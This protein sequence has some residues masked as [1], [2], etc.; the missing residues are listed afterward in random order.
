M[1]LSV[2]AATRTHGED[3]REGATRV[4]RVTLPPVSRELLDRSGKRP[5]PDWLRCP[6]FYTKD[7]RRPEMQTR[8]PGDIARMVVEIA[9][10]EGEVF[11]L[12]GYWGG[13]VYFQSKVAPHAPGLGS[14]D[15]L[16]EGTEEGKRRGVKIVMYMNPNALFPEHPLFQ[17]VAARLPNGQPTDYGRRDAIVICTNHPRFREF[18]AEVVA[19]GFSNYDVE[20][21]YVDGLSPH[22]CCCRHCQAKYRQM[23]NEDLPTGKL[24]LVRQ[25]WSLWEMV[26][27]PLPVGD[28]A[29]PDLDRYRQFLHRSQTEI[30][31]LVH[32]TV[33]RCKADAVVTFHTW[34][35]PETVQFYDATV[36]EIYVERPWIHK[37]WKYGELANLGSTFSIP[38]LCNI[39]LE[40]GSEAE[41]RYKMFQV[42]ANGAY[43]NCWGLKAMKPMF[44]FL[45]ENAEYYDFA[46]T[47]PVR[48][49][50]IPREIHLSQVHR[51]LGEE[52]GYNRSHEH[53]LLPGI[54]LYSALE[55]SGLPVINL[56]AADFQRQLGGFRV[57]CLSHQIGMSPEQVEQVRRFVARG[58]GLIA[59][60]ETSL[61]D[62]KA[63]RQVDFQLADVFGATFQAM[64]P[65]AGREIRIDGEEFGA[66]LRSSSIPHQESHLLVQPTTGRAVARLVGE[67]TTATGAPA[68]IVNRFGRG[69]VVY[70]P[71][72]LDLAEAKQPSPAIE[73]LFAAAV[74]WVAGGELPVEMETEDL[75]GAT[76]YDQPDRRLLHLVSHNT[77]SQFRNDDVQ[78]A[79][80]V[81]IQ[82][83]IPDRRRLV[84]VH[85]LWNKREVPFE[86]N[87]SL[88][89]CEL[90]PMGPYEV[91][92]A[93]LESQG[94]KAAGPAPRVEVEHR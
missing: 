17:E 34:P 18:R 42:V 54:G 39:Y 82:L 81:A 36:T 44:G 85:T 13:E 57:L 30:M 23:W 15:F 11:R 31:R 37:A 8:K 62:H 27:E 24:E 89:R 70:L 51:K 72:R 90:D 67:G 68:V 50:A 3:S 16:R 56:H 84:R 12:G 29:D 25:W 76:L 47:T 75:V 92:V 19:E 32:D 69:R 79:G 49:L 5:V 2:L 46:R 73:R 41:A 26:P 28:P 61:Y 91:L 6:R 21:L 35:K 64:L 66:A 38:S 20:G 33:K 86:A 87:G 58:G 60:C 7:S 94:A 74:R 40:H 45:R 93:E 88:L 48:F 14:M 78:P 4:E 55:R 10:N 63:E 53:F 9:E 22:R 77:D 1:F 80:K 59:T 83:R 52:M 65:A 43:P 71:G